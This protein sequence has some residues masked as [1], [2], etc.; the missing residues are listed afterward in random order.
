MAEAGI[1]YLS[2]IQRVSQ[3]FTPNFTYPAVLTMD[4]TD[5]TQSS[6]CGRLELV[7]SG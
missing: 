1:G 4:G 5:D 7:R 2:G 3:G 6:S